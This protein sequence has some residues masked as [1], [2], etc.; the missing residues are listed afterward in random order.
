VS[1]IVRH[2]IELQ[3]KTRFDRAHLKGTGPHSYVFEAVYYVLDPGYN[4]YMDIHEA[5]NLHIIRAL[6]REEIAFAYPT[7]TLFLTRGKPAEAGPA[8]QRAAVTIRRA[9]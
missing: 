8:P 3:E 5:V 6:Q 1:G 2:A 7:Q 4:V 9:T